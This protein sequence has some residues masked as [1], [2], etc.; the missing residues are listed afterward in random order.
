MDLSPVS[1]FAPEPLQPSVAGGDASPSSSP[2]FLFPATEGCLFAAQ[3]RSFVGD[4]TQ[5]ARQG[6][7]ASTSH[8]RPRCPLAELPKGN[9][10]ASHCRAGGARRPAAISSTFPAFRGRPSTTTRTA[11]A[12][13]GSLQRP[14]FSSSPHAHRHPPAGTGA[15]RSRVLRP[16]QPNGAL[17]RTRLRSPLSFVSLGVGV[18]SIRVLLGNVNK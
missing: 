18:P 1:L 8:S 16:S 10:G 15:P 2:S 11:R 13:R 9:R 14:T 12:P 3:P 5:H 7:V 6:P 17:Q 4:A